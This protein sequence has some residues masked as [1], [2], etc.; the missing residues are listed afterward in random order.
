MCLKTRGLSLSS[1][2]AIWVE[3]TLSLYPSF[4]ETIAINYKATLQSHDF[5]NKP[6]EAVKKVNLWATEKT[7]GLITDVLSCGSIDSLTRLIFANALYFK[8]AW[9]QPFDASETKDYDFHLLDGSSFK[10][11]FKTSRESQFISVF[12]GFKVLRL[13]YEHGT[14]DDRHFSMY[15]LLP[16]AKDG[17]SAL[18]EKVASEYETLEHILP[19]SIVDVGDFRIPSFEISFGFELSNMLKELGVILPFSNGGLTKIVDSPLWISNITQKSIIKVNEVGT[20]A[21]AVTVTGIAGCSQFTS[22]PTPIDF[23]ADHP[24]L[25][26]IREDLSGTILFVGQ[27]L[28]PLLK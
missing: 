10:V 7:N 20:E 5:I 24:F 26:F 6:D 8:G 4:K 17:L 23:V 12:D 2:Y 25:F 3:K 18:I 19:D 22:I 11:P 16:D 21:A 28:N 9:H 14:I 27:V 13:P 1:A 15:F